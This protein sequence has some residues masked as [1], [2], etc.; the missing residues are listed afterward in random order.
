MKTEIDEFKRSVISDLTEIVPVKKIEYNP[1]EQIDALKR[2]PVFHPEAE[3]IET[4]VLE[5]RFEGKFVIGGRYH[6][7]VWKPGPL[8]SL[9]GVQPVY[10]GRD[11]FLKTR[12]T[13]HIFEDMTDEELGKFIRGEFN[14]FK[15]SIED[16][17]KSKKS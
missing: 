13:H 6:K 10:K 5:F 8:A 1:V 15:Q 4:E 16:W 12:F 3:I 11:F 17:K 14:K 9:A 7:M 2:S